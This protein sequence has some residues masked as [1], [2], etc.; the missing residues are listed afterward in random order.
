MFYV[1]I[2]LCML[3]VIVMFVL[4]PA[5]RIKLLQY[6]GYLAGV[7]VCIRIISFLF[8]SVANWPVTSSHENTKERVLLI[9][10]VL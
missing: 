3:I 8:L 1:H 6:V 5:W 7:H 10:L 4:L 2:C 9:L